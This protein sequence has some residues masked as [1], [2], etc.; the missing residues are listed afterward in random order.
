MNLAQ[1]LLRAWRARGKP[2]PPAS[3]EP[4]AF[5]RGDASGSAFKDVET[6]ADIFIDGDRTDSVFR[7][8]VHRRER[9]P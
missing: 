8:V 2:A 6:D 5:I 7:N 3:R 9:Q 4:S 1:A